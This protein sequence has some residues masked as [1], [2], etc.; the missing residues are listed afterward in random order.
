[1]PDFN[2]SVVRIA[3]CHGFCRSKTEQRELLY[4]LPCPNP[5]V[6]PQTTHFSHGW[7]C[8]VCGTI[9]DNNIGLILLVEQDLIAGGHHHLMP[10]L[11]PAQA[12]RPAAPSWTI[13]ETIKAADDLVPP[14][15]LINKVAKALGMDN[16]PA[17]AADPD[18]TDGWR[19]GPN[20]PFGNK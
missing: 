2:P 15:E 6:C 19:P 10:E 8:T 17:I 16:F 20:L 7:R 14:P 9:D 5:L 13:D 1:M 3:M 12:K 11:W 4:A 18:T